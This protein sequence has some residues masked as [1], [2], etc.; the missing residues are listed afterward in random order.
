MLLD[1]LVSDAAIE[2]ANILSSETGQLDITHIA[3][4]SRQVVP[5]SLFVAVVGSVHDGH[6]FIPDALQ[7]GAVAM[8][9]SREERPDT[10]P[11]GVPYLHVPD[12]RASVALLSAAF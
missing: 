1:R 12:D 10:L 4:N 3:E 6:K 7:R 5:G 8:A 2:G 11:E 9:G